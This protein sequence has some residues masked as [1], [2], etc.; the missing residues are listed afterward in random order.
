M[1]KND[2]LFSDFI[3]ALTMQIV[4]KG[5]QG[6]FPLQAQNSIFFGTKKVSVCGLWISIGSA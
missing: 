3:A 6:D 2:F 4:R 1:K 5:G